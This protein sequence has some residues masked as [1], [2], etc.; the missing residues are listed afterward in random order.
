MQVEKMKKIMCVLVAMLM[1]LSVV[2]I[3]FAQDAGTEET[4][5]VSDATV[6][7]T[8]ETVVEEPVA[9]AEEPTEEAAPEEAVVEETLATEEVVEEA[10]ITPDQPVL[11]AIEN[12]VEDVNVALTFD[13][14][15]QAELSLEYAQESVS[16]MEVM[17]E[18]GN[19]EALETA[20]EAAEEDLT[21][22]QEAAAEISSDDPAEELAVQAEIEAQLEEQ[23]SHAAQVKNAILTRMQSKWSPEKYA[24]ISANFAR[25]VAKQDAVKAGLKEKQL[26]TKTKLQAKTGK[27]AEGVE[28]DASADAKANEKS[29]TKP[30]DAKDADTEASEPSKGKGKN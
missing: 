8:T 4:E 15:E 2:S 16:E 7:T 18:E 27:S 19:L 3:A 10:G 21:D 9:V 11:Y 23:L 1:L 28:G 14:A 6:D 20:T 13:E 30:K 29:Q 25:I 26:K 17:A 12:A 22:A 5:V 24:Q